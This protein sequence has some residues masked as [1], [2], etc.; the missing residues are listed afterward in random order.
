MRH[1]HHLAA[2]LLSLAEQTGRDFKWCRKCYTALTDW[3]KFP[4]TVK[5]RIPSHSTLKRLKQADLL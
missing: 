2:E 4:A 1:D 5:P 3:R